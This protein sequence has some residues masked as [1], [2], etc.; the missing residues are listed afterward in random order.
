M[1][2]RNSNTTRPTSYR[3]I[4][5][6]MNNTTWIYTFDVLQMNNAKWRG[7]YEIARHVQ[8][9][10]I[11]GSNII[12]AKRV[13]SSTICRFNP[14]FDRCVG[15]SRLLPL[16]EMPYCSCGQ[17]GS[18]YAR[19]SRLPFAFVGNSRWSSVGIGAS[20]LFRCARTALL[21]ANIVILVAVDVTKVKCIYCCKILLQL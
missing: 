5:M 19:E 4:N 13:L 8:S 17:S 12:N 14:A 11:L 15:I 2:A 7:E 6:G 20:G 18:T 16:P 9:M 3:T 21:P 1:N 10:N